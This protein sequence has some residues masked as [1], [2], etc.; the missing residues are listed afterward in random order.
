MSDD[1]DI[2][3]QVRTAL[4]LD[5]ASA[6]ISAPV[7]HLKRILTNPQQ[8][9]A[10]ESLL[11]TIVPGPPGS[12]AG[13]HPLLWQG[14]PPAALPLGNLYLVFEPAAGG[15]TEVGVAGE[16]HTAAGTTPSVAVSARLPLVRTSGANLV[17]PG[18]GG[19]VP[20]EIGVA[21]DQ[22]P[23]GANVRIGGITVA[24]RAE[25]GEHPTL[26][27]RL[28]VHG[29]ALGTAAPR[30]LV[31][32]ASELG[33][34]A[35]DLALSLVHEA[36]EN[37]PEPL[38]THL[39]PALGL[40]P[41]LPQLPLLDLVHDPEA[42][43]RFFASLVDAGKL[44]EWFGHVVALFTG[45][46]PVF[47]SSGSREDPFVADLLGGSVRVALTLATGDGR[48]FPGVA[49]RVGQSSQVQLSADLVLLGIPLR[50][51]TDVALLPE[52]SLTLR[53]PTPL[54]APVVDAGGKVIASA[55]GARAGVAIVGGRPQGLLELVEVTLDGH[56]HPRVDLTN[57]DAVGDLAAN[58]VEALLAEALGSGPAQHLLVLA[59]AALPTIGTHP[60]DVWSQPNPP[61]LDFVRLLSDPLGALADFHRRVLQANGWNALLAHLAALVGKQ[62]AVSG[63]GTADD[64]W[65]FAV[66][67]DGP[68]SV[69]AV[70]SKTGDVDL[71]L[72]VAIVLEE[73]PFRASLT[74]EIVRIR[75]PPSGNAD[76]AAVGGLHADLVIGPLPRLPVADGLGVRAQSIALGVAFRIGEPP[77]AQGSVKQIVLTVGG[78]DLPAFD[79]AYPLTGALALGD[80]VLRALLA[81]AAQRWGGQLATAVLAA[82]G[83]LSGT[84]GLPADFPTLSGLSGIGLAALRSWAASVASGASATDGD[85]YALAWFR[86][87]TA[88]LTGLLDDPR[89]S[90]VV[91]GCGIDAEPWRAALSSGGAFELLSWLEPTPATASVT[92]ALAHAAD[93]S[94]ACAAAAVALRAFRPDVRR[95][96]DDVDGPRLASGIDALEEFLGQSDGVVPLASQAPAAF[97]AGAQVTSSHT[98]AIAAAASA[99]RTEI[100]AARAVLLAAPFAEH[101]SFAAVLS[102][103]ASANFDL[104]H[105]GIPPEQVDLSGV[106]TAEQFY[107]A[108]L[109]GADVQSLTA[110]VG[111]ILDRLDAILPGEPLVLV[112]HSVTGLAAV[113]AAEAAPARVS[114]V[115]TVATPHLG[116]AAPYLADLSSDA[117]LRLSSILAAQ[118]GASSLTD[119][120]ADA[121]SAV[122]G[123]PPAGGVAPIPV[124]AMADPRDAPA[125]PAVPVVAISATAGGGF[126]AALIA[127]LRAVAPAASD[128]TAAAMGLAIHLDAPV[129]TGEVAVDTQVRFDLG[130]LGLSSGAAS[131]IL[132]RLV[133]QTTVGR[134]DEW[135]LG[136]PGTQPDGTPWPARIR[137]AVFRGAWD[138]SS[139]STD[140]ELIDAGLQGSTATVALSDAAAPQL[141][142]AL[143]GAIA[144]E[145]SAASWL[146]ALRK[147]GIVLQDAPRLSSDALGALTADGSAF[148]GPRLRAALAS[149]TTLDPF[150]GHAPDTGW[151]FGFLSVKLQGSQAVVHF[152][153]PLL[154]GDLAVALPALT[155][156]GGLSVK[157][158]IFTF[159]WQDGTL[160]LSV[161]PWL[162][163]V[164]IWPIGAS[165][166]DSL[167]RVAFSAA[168]DALLRAISPGGMPWP[169]LDALFSGTASLANTALEFNA[170]TLS[171]LL[172]RLG[173]AL[174]QPA[175]D[176]LL[177][178][179]AGLKLSARDA[180]NGKIGLALQTTAPVGGV[181]GVNVKLTFSGG[182]RVEPSGH[183]TLTV[184]DPPSSAGA[185]AW[186]GVSLELGAGPSGVTAALNVG[187]TRVDFLPFGGWSSL[188]SGGV[189][190]LP[191][192]LDEIVQRIPASSIKNAVLDVARALDLYDPTFVAH[193]AQFS[194]L[195]S[196]TFD[197]THRAQLLSAAGTLLA[198]LGLPGTVLHPAAGPLTWTSPAF[199]AP[200]AGQVS[201]VLDWSGTRPAA[202][203]RGGIEI[204]AA[205]GA[206]ALDTVTL[207]AGIDAL[208]GDGFRALAQIGLDRPL[209]T[210]LLP[211]IDVGVRQGTKQPEAVLRLL[212]LGRLGDDG[213][214]LVDGPVAIE[215]L[216]QV[217]ATIDSGALIAVLG[218]DFL[219]PLATSL[220][221]RVAG[222]TTLWP[223]GPTPTALVVASGIFD[224]NGALASPMPD[225]PAILGNV[226][227]AMSV[228]IQLD[229]LTLTVGS[230]G[231]DRVGAAASGRIAIPVDSMELDLVLGEDGTGPGLE[232][233]ELVLFA[234]ASGS[235]AFAPALS[236]N[237]FG[238]GLRGQ[239]GAPLV[240]ND[241]VRL[242]GAD[243]FTF[244]DVSSTQGSL[245]AEFRGAG[246]EL[247][248]FGLSIGEATGGDNAVAS[249]LMKSTA[250][251]NGA[252]AQPAFGV[253][254]EYARPS[255][256]ENEAGTDFHLEIRLQ[257]DDPRRIRVPIHAAFGPV[258]ID[259]VDV[260]LEKIED[261]SWIEVGVDGGVS[262]SGFE[263][264]VDDLAVR[265]PFQ[266]A[267]D[268]SKWSIDLQGL[269]IAY[270]NGSVSI[271]G[272]L[273][274][275][276][277][278][279]SGVEYAGMLRLR[280][281]EIGAVAVGAWAKQQDL[282]SL[283]IFAGVFLTITFA[284]Y[285][286]LEGLGA[287]F[288]YNR[289]LVVPEDVTE[290]PAFPL[291][292]VLDDPA[293][294][295]DPMALLDQLDTAL[296]I[297]RGSFWLAVGL[298]GSLFVVVDLV[299]VVYAALDS[300]FEIGVLAVGRLEQPEGEPLVSVELALKARYST[301]DQILSI[302]AQLTD[303]SWLLVSE[304]QLTGGFAL[305]IWFRTGQFVLTVGGY[306]PAFDPPPEF[307]VVPRVGFRLQLG[308]IQIKGETYF[309]LT[310]SVVM[311]G[312]ALEASYDAGWLKAWFRAWTDLLLSWDPFHYDA[313]IG[314]Q[315]GADFEIDVDLLFGTVTMD[316][317]VS[318]GASL[319]I[320]GP[321]LH[322]EVKADLGPISVTIPFGSAAT[323][324]P[325]AL[326]WATFRDKYV[327]GGD[328]S[329]VPVSAQPDTGIV[330]PPSGSKPPQGETAADPLRLVCEFSFTTT[331]AMPAAHVSALGLLDQDVSGVEVDFA[332]MSAAAVAT[333]HRVTLTKRDGSAIPPLNAADWELEQRMGN[334]AEAV[335]RIRSSPNAGAEN[336]SALSGLVIRAVPAAL[337]PT[338]AI[339]IGTLTQTGAPLP[340]PFASQTPAWRNNTIALGNSANAFG[341]T[342]TGV[343]TDKLLRRGS[344]AHDG[345][346]IRNPASSGTALR[347]LGQRVSPPLVAPLAEGMDLGPP[348]RG[349]P[350]VVVKPPPV[351]VVPEPALEH[352]TFFK[353]APAAPVARTTARAAADLPRTAPPAPSVSVGRF[354][355]LP[356]QRTAAS[357][358]L[359]APPLARGP[360]AK[361]RIA[362]ANS[363]VQEGG[364]EVAAG[365]VHHWS[366][367]P[368]GGW[369]IA[370]SGDASRVVA[371]ARGGDALLDVEVSGEFS[372]ALPDRTVA[373]AVW[374]LGRA[375][376]SPPGPGFAALSLSAAPKPVFAVGW[377][378]ESQLH[379]VGD[380][381][382]LVR[383][384]RLKLS[385]ATRDRGLVHATR[386]LATQ[387]TTETTLPGAIDAVLLVG[388]LSDPTA[389][390]RTDLVVG[391][392]G[393]SVGAP[394]LFGSR[395]EEAALYPVTDRGT[396]LRI[397]V[398]S[399]T[400][401]R[402]TGVVG[403]R[404][405]PKELAAR[406]HGT[407]LRGL[408]PDGPLTAGGSVRL[409]MFRGAR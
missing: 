261:P 364:V 293:S 74:S 318:V 63:T 168:A 284:P 384:A 199:A 28:E 162:H 219:L 83:L 30:D 369:R 96:I 362:A 134:N 204:T 154:S 226:A 289:A 249:G 232:R 365:A 55:G 295:D 176:G 242:G 159:T 116:T 72:G 189:A 402:L 217:N 325:P 106:S 397:A 122:S 51:A 107:T 27:P 113:A 178:A 129:G 223:G 89:R 210:A 244:F 281:S 149:A 115:V 153:D 97:T 240:S 352:A 62:T 121:R 248:N 316:F 246:V 251:G 343:S 141:L 372:A 220:L 180:G 283:F 172:Q 311:A 345:L 374:S 275:R 68:I 376:A 5:D 193:A 215:F 221:Q 7:D 15:E 160:A 25:L 303:N 49:A 276:A 286:Q 161:E 314:I 184:P 360:A 222:T 358:A 305:F 144:S 279:P 333:A 288:G 91:R 17:A 125:A 54:L 195:T 87:V 48:L 405:Q 367:P 61:R 235:Y 269:G 342:W 298:K 118:F 260:E 197:A 202:T 69:R 344:P 10:L 145:P 255:G 146:D 181:L 92:F 82:A 102:G 243:A 71:H 126:Q 143:F 259:Q 272:G 136:G 187:T 355:R 319:R 278:S 268:L 60:G 306:H 58:A 109:A 37:A 53:S 329:A 190:L 263:A 105:P 326:P 75:A 317:S 182:T 309:A 230:L 64:P 208:L 299:A 177:I 292:S 24:L 338:V 112:A 4:G 85:P 381:T 366:V 250:G 336:I 323:S 354:V 183:V 40:D 238:V 353:S 399:V 341:T 398:G 392:T 34:D 19:G 203:V 93:G 406:L 211:R 212:P 252:P 409:R 111:R 124:A 156:S 256:G 65:A 78:V 363:A 265:I 247:D 408:V 140:V 119:A 370:L 207:R 52:A 84:L 133:V 236:A 327:L 57:L 216:P 335:W 253:S 33:R 390:A 2:V 44:G 38:R 254:V 382:A 400:G 165:L 81:L 12:R 201:I 157:I 77:V 378:S 239:D 297:R 171:F 35:A 315:L 339:P 88:A 379:V 313:S 103:A 258:H 56:A 234:R 167:P 266:A 294:A 101:G 359:V 380:R 214:T 357:A 334:F 152:D 16:F 218:R 337:H 73:T 351:V 31:L 138:G 179:T 151:S 110:Q 137:R 285:F 196:W 282:D 209:G 132:H 164:P 245:T 108:D 150:Y 135:L 18:A 158:S 347:S 280:L 330:P 227:A 100:G 228:A 308:D 41:S 205:S 320:V 139:L 233:T 331:T 1:A 9:E 270:D 50:G 273:L 188:L 300:H 346:P 307:P 191:H 79:L 391:V 296:P 95:A 225:I 332:P 186:R 290:V 120:L 348:G 371:L 67:D 387:P 45:A 287:G 340:L 407:S 389:A 262:V 169:P 213:T 350:Q 173:A 257:G 301:A 32:D 23:A 304:C 198:D 127:A 237:H 241:T 6:F 59:G 66:A 175:S 349:V 70:A 394:S 98:N 147:L 200:V 375:P 36:L 22:I 46:A 29:F 8:R 13:W 47:A 267:G 206:T 377:Q 21:L 43:R 163:A 192:A 224:A 174:G 310:N 20:F 396:E 130:R 302:Q 166:L 76:L 291:V 11:D 131:G 361:I 356:P 148:L 26:S 94:D 368:G 274:K 170:T 403:L 90:V 39:L 395:T 194:A 14:D 373:V 321:P 231:G 155:L 117:A 328:P 80:A 324:A 264:G 385:S 386:L 312:A 393:G 99:I 277:L 128:P 104:R 322:G 404:G 388:A 123:A 401:Y 271:A 185:G 3:S 86:L 383:G 42:G 114:K 229:G 142:D